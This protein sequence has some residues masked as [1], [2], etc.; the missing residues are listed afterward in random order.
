MKSKHSKI[1]QFFEF[2]DIFGKHAEIRVNSR[3]KFHTIS[4]G[5]FTVIYISLALFFFYSFGDDMFSRS[6]PETGVSEIYEPS[7]SPTKVAKNDYFFAFGIQDRNDNHFIDEEIYYPI[8]IYGYQ[9]DSMSEPVQYKIPLEPCSETVLPDNKQLADYFKHQANNISDLYCISK[10]N[11]LDLVI[12]GAWD[13]Q[14]FDYLQILIYPCNKSE[15]LCKSDDLIKSALKS[16]FFGFYSIDNLFDLNNYNEPAKKIG[17]DY[18]TQTTFTLKKIITRYLQTSHVV[19]DDG[20]ISSSNIRNERFSWSYDLASF[21]II[22]EGFD[23]IIDFQIK[24]SNYENVFIRKYKKIQNVLAEMSGFCQIIFIALYFIS[25]PF[26]KKE[27]YDIL[28]NKI[29]NFELDEDDDIKKKPKRP[30]EKKNENLEKI[31]KLKSIRTIINGDDDGRFPND[32]EKDKT[33]NSLSIK[34][35]RAIDKLFNFFFKLKENPLNLSIFQLIKG[36]LFKKPDFMVK[37]NQRKVGISSIFSQLDIHY[38]LKKFAEIEK[39]KVL[40]LNEDQYHLF[41]YLPKPV[42]LKNSQ[43]R[44]NY[45]KE[46]YNNPLKNEEIRKSEIFLEGDLITRAKS[47]HKAYNNIIRKPN[48]NEIDRKLIESLDEDIMNILD[49]PSPNNSRSKMEETCIF[50]K[51]K[52]YCFVT[53]KPENISMAMTSPPRIDMPGDTQ[54]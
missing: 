46:Q 33:G 21:E 24:K 39:L 53:E 31:E 34:N 54:I 25:N 48:M 52:D 40:L 29:Y 9:N 20:W 7:P 38:F 2:I 44:I 4:G 30:K 35:K 12:Q 50:T 41:Q 23:N 43:I 32:K 18:F 45:A 17:R 11:I 13:Q 3:P 16:S 5:I 1:S 8:L 51:T 19:S 47:V 27:Y 37:K 26:I 14:N 10:N 22:D 28:T 42:I 6:N 49:I 15:T 36:S